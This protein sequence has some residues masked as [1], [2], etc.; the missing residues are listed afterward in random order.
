M[1]V[2]RKKQERIA[3]NFWCPPS[4]T[5]PQCGRRSGRL[6]QADTEVKREV[7]PIISTPRSF[8]QGWPSI[9][10]V[11]LVL[12]LHFLQAHAQTGLCRPLFPPQAVCPNPLRAAGFWNP[13]A[14]TW[15][16]FGSCCSGPA[17]HPTQDI[18]IQ[19]QTKRGKMWLHYKRLQSLGTV[20]ILGSP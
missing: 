19:K 2:S 14:L 11:M 18:K 7:C 17:V 4:L 5:S 10:S 12:L 13:P 20:Y 15:T 6:T 16:A 9:L 8:P 3:G 1:D